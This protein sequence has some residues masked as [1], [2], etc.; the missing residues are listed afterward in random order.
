M[1]VYLYVCLPIIPHMRCSYTIFI[2]KCNCCSINNIR[3]GILCHSKSK[4][5]G[6]EFSAGHNIRGN[7]HQ[8]CRSVV[9]CVVDGASRY[10]IVTHFCTHSCVQNTGLYAYIQWMNKPG[11]PFEGTP[12]VVRLKDNYPVLDASNAM[13]RLWNCDLVDTQRLF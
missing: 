9:T 13:I 10:G 8:T 4:I 2:G 12:L 7:Q 3:A 5:C 1:H 11:Y 6:V